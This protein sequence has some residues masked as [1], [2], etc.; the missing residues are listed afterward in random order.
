[1]T[2]SALPVVLLGVTL[3]ATL[4]LGLWWQRRQGVVR[5][6]R[7]TSPRATANPGAAPFDW[8]AHGVALGAR[9]TF[10][11]FSAELCAPC[12]ATA[13][14]LGEVSAAHDGVTHREMDVDDHL[15]LVRAFGILR[16]PTVLVLDAEGR[17]V[18]RASGGM[19][20]AQALAALA[21]ADPGSI[22]TGVRDA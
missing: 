22:P 18:A 5:T 15:D 3:L 14:V 8:P 2:S 9:R 17:E 12:R 20:R 10:V 13:R 4:A 1:M 16:T 19:N 21:V 11:Q 6:A 7:S